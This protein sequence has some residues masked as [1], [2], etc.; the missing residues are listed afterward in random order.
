M[1]QRAFVL[2]RIQDMHCS[3][4]N[5]DF[6]RLYS[7]PAPFC[8][9]SMLEISLIMKFAPQI[10]DDVA[11]RFSAGCGSIEKTAGFAQHHDLERIDER[12]FAG[13]GNTGE[14]I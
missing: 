10:R 11:V 4:V 1:S 6:Y 9:V 7:P 8:R 5:P 14:E 2:P 13:T 3:A 12:G